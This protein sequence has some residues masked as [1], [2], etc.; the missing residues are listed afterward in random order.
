MAA[1][2][3]LRDAMHTQ[4]F[5][6]F[7][8]Y[9]ADGRNYLVRHPDFIAYGPSYRD[10]TVHDDQGVHLIDMRNVV[11]LHAPPAPM[12]PEHDAAEGGS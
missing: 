7:M 10:L 6:P 11:E 8:V 3:Q 5:R 4:P 12:A 1:I 2:D 9:L